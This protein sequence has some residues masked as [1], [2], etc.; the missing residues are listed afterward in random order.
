MMKKQLWPMF[1]I[2]GMITSTALMPQNPEHGNSPL[3]S[4]QRVEKN[5]LTIKNGTTDAALVKICDAQTDS[6][7]V[8]VFI[9]AGANKTVKLPNGQYREFVRFGEDSLA[10]QYHKGEGF[11]LTAPADGFIEATLTL[12]GVVNGNYST[13]PS[14]K[15]EFESK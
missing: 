10:Y 3:P 12:Y 1:I 13:E 9:P 15:E 11:E 5:D 6:V 7:A 8:M 2:L 14:S 4:E